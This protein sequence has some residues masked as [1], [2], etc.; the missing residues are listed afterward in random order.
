MN[1]KLYWIGVVLWVAGL[2][3]SPVAGADETDPLPAPKGAPRERAIVVYN[4]GVKLLRDKH[5]AAA[6][7]K[8]EQAL[9]LDEALAEGH[10]NLAF[11][12]RLQGTHHFERALKHYNRALELKPDLAQ[13]YMYRGVL[14]TQMGDLPRARADHAKLLTLDQELAAKLERIIAGADGHG[15]YDGMA[16]QDNR[17]Q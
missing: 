13:A 15:E 14:F 16:A 7:E 3:L 4:E 12:R 9:G 6:Q 11:S 8:F 10:N 2:L 5:Y 1:R 17:A